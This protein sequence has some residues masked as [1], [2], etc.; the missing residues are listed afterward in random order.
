MKRLKKI[1]MRMRLF[2]PQHCPGSMLRIPSTRMLAQEVGSLPLTTVRSV[3]IQM[4]G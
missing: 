2:P 3:A 4:A 1:L